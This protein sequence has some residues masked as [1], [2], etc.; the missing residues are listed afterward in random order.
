[1]L[2]LASAPG[3]RVANGRAILLP[4]LILRAGNTT[5]DTC[6]CGAQNALSN[7]QAACSGKQACYMVPGLQG[8]D[9]SFCEPDCS[10]ACPAITDP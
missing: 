2:H 6:S 4:T 7:A 5:V 3:G 1:V 10:V 9:I 8:E